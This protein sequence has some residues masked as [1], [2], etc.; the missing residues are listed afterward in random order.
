MA[1]FSR[2]IWAPWRMQYIEGLADREPGCFLCRACEHPEDDEKNFVLWRSPRTLVVQ[3]RFPYTSG[4]VLIA[5]AAHQ[6]RL[7]NLPDDVLLELMQRM[8]DVQRVLELAFKAQGFNIGMNIG[9]CAGAGLPDHL[10][11]H[12]VPRWAGDTNFMAVLADV[13]VIPEALAMVQQRFRQAAQQ[14]GLGQ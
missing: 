6:P 14:L 7:E 4:H 13:K 3:N 9:H 5:P 11:W 10:H 1:E 8:R 2:D 12:V